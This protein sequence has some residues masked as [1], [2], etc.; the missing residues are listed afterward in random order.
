MSPC[1]LQLISH[2]T[3]TSL[4]QCQLPRRVNPLPLLVKAPRSSLIIYWRINQSRSN[5]ARHRRGGVVHRA[6]D[7]DILGL[8]A[9]DLDFQR[10][11]I[12]VVERL[13]E[14]VDFVVKLSSGAFENKVE[15]GL[16]AGLAEGAVA[17]VG[18]GNLVKVPENVLEPA[19][20]V[21]V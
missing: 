21:R 7:K 4:D 5:P 2:S 12:R 18:Q 15:R 6:H 9:C 11:V 14:G 8:R 3:N 13:D 17:V 20:V 16:E 1:Q 10:L 19:E